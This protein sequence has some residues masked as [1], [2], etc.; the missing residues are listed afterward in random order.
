MA[1]GFKRTLRVPFLVKII[2]QLRSTIDNIIFV[3]QGFGKTLHY[4]TY[5]YLKENIGTKLRSMAVP[6]TV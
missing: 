2:I 6:S 1:E 4:Q 3:Q 5:K